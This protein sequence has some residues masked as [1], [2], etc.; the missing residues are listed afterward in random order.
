MKKVVLILAL[1]AYFAIPAYSGTITLTSSVTDISGVPYV[2]CSN[3]Q[4]S[5]TGGGT[6]TSGSWQTYPLNTLNID[7]GSLSPGCNSNIVLPA[8]T[9]RVYAD[10]TF[11]NCNGAQLRLYNNTNSSVITPGITT[12]SDNGGLPNVDSYL[13][14][15]FTIS[16]AK[17]LILQYQVSTTV[18]TSGLGRAQ[19][20]GTEVYGFI[21]FLKIS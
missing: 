9:Y 11:Y 18:A 7:S 1:I 16:A 2:N 10:V 12:R 20:F 17:T 6:A 8:G 3:T 13:S 15:Q 19:S 14:Y 21:D 5:G 4:A